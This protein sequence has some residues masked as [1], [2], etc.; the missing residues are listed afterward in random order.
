MLLTAFTS[1]KTTK[2]APN[3]QAKLIDAQVKQKTTRPRQPIAGAAEVMNREE[4][5]RSFRQR[6]SGCKSFRSYRDQYTVVKAS[7]D[8]ARPATAKKNASTD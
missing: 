8:N 3:A 6:V 4:S 5:A 1:L 2:V 7:Q